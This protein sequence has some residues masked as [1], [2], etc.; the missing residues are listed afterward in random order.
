MTA[1]LGWMDSDSMD[2]AE[3]GVRTRPLSDRLGIVLCHISLL[4]LLMNHIVSDW[5]CMAYC[6]QH[7]SDL[8]HSHPIPSSSVYL[9]PSVSAP[10]A[11][12]VSHLGPR[13]LHTRPSDVMPTQQHGIRS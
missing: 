5:V 9:V 6:H 7:S 8:V 3:A 11:S 12:C 2:S 4:L 1:D 13:P 10:M